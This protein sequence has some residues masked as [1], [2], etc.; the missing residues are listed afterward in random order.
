MGT[1]ENSG[2]NAQKIIVKS[3]LGVRKINGKCLCFPASEFAD[4]PPACAIDD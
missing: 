2:N 1:G 4:I 3:L